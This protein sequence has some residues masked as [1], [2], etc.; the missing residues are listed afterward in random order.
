MVLSMERWK[1]KVAIVT[2]TSS[3]IGAAIAEE[4]VGYGMQVSTYTYLTKTRKGPVLDFSGIYLNSKLHLCFC[5][6]SGIG[7]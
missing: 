4:L 7:S 1:G 2:G 6:G 5:T 3:G